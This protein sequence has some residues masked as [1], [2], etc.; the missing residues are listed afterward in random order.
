MHTTANPVGEVHV[1][2]HTQTRVGEQ[3]M[4]KE[5]LAP[6]DGGGED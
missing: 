1:G 2:M 6:W 4:W 5:L 3:G